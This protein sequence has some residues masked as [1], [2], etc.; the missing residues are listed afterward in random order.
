MPT[1]AIAP[2]KAA[3][4][5]VNA[6]AVDGPN[7]TAIVAP[8][9]A[10]AAAPSRYGSASGFRNTAWYAAPDAESDAPTSPATITRGRRRFP[11][12]AACW[13]DIPGG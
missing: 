10:P 12:I 1:P 13:S 4:G 6:K 2:T 11:R 7:A 9:P 5:T 8:R 3:S